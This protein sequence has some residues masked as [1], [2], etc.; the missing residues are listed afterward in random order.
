MR[1]QVIF[2]EAD[3]PLQVFVN[4]AAVL[5]CEGNLLIQEVKVPGFGDIFAGCPRV[6][7]YG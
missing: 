7:R 1:P 5:I 2:G 6:R 4:S 3:G